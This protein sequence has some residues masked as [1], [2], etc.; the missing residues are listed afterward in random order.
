MAGKKPVVGVASKTS[1]HK[2]LKEQGVGRIM[3]ESNHSRQLEEINSSNFKAVGIN[4]NESIMSR[5]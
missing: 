2:C 4:N 1:V 5:E 3:K